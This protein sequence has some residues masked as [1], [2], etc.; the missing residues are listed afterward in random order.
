[1][2]KMTANGKFNRL[3]DELTELLDNVQLPQFHKFLGN[4][5]VQDILELQEDYLEL[6]RNSQ[7]TPSLRADLD[8]TRKERDEL[9]VKIAKLTSGELRSS[10]MAAKLNEYERSQFDEAGKLDEFL[11]HMNEKQF[12]NAIKLYRAIFGSGL[13]DAKDRVEEIMGGFNR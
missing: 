9:K 4:R 7:Y 11:L 10:N 3:H 6:E 12:I 1:M 2:S 13:K 8:Q 5:M